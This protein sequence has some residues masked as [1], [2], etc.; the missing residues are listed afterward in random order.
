MRNKNLGFQVFQFI[1]SRQG[2]R[3]WP[4]SRH[5]LPSSPSQQEEE[6]VRVA[7][8]GATRPPKP[9]GG[10]FGGSQGGS[11]NVISRQN[12]PSTEQASLPPWE[13]L[14]HCQQ[15][16]GLRAAA[17]PSPTANDA[18]SDNAAQNHLHMFVLVLRNPL[19]NMEGTGSRGRQHL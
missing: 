2:S 17:C 14:L 19:V 5:P 8:S 9:Q 18:P 7:L 1:C 12:A 15:L 16:P 11:A 6:K 13:C 10:L 3:Q 4:P